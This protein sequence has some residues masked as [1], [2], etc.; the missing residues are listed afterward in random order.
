[1]YTF[2]EQKQIKIGDTPLVELQTIQKKLGLSA[3][4]FAKVEKENSGG[5]IKDRVAQA[6]LND[7]EKTGALKSGGTVIEATSGNTGIGL[8]MLCKERGYRAVIVMPDTMS[9]ERR[10]L[11]KSYGAE[12][13]LTDGKGGMTASVEKA[14]EILK[15]TPN[16]IMAKQ[17]EN[18]AG[19]A[20]HY[21]GTAPEIERQLPATLDVFVAAVGSGGTLTGVGKYFKEKNAAMRVVAV[22]P[23][24]SPLLSQGRAGA[25]GIQ[26]I[27]AN[28]IPKILDTTLYDE[29]LTVTDEDAIETA[30]L[31]KREEDLFVGISSGANVAAAIALA[32]REENF[33]K[34]IVTVL[35]DGGERY[36]IW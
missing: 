14:N 7:A 22:E 23:A 25:H 30:K 29:V 6:I 33:N 19:V 2:S 32:K 8:A 3:R 13:V 28:F 18:F 20:A 12:V 16:A 21:E 17:F 26:G 1:M 9:L 4:I 35:P 24:K 10:R 31:L 27:G 5:S 34:T 11:L 36:E 15:N